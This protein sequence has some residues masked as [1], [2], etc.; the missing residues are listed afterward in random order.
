MTLS[1][2]DSFP[3]IDFSDRIAAE[4][5]LIRILTD[6]DPDGRWKSH[7]LYQR[8]RACRYGG[9]AIGEMDR[10]IGYL[11][12]CREQLTPEQYRH[13]LTTQVATAPEITDPTWSMEDDDAPSQETSLQTVD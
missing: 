3:N 11:E 4:S 13:W 12:G 7:E 2:T 1:K 10:L 8:R 9:L 6:I 5:A